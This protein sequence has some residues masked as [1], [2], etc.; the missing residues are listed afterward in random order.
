MSRSVDNSTGLWIA[1]LSHL[2]FETPLGS[3][4]SLKYFCIQIQSILSMII[5]SLNTYSS[6]LEKI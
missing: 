3:Y 6:K 4:P 2:A 1:L 5:F